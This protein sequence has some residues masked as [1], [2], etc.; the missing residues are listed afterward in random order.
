MPGGKS[1]VL[2]PGGLELGAAR[3]FHTTYNPP[4]LL[5]R[6]PSYPEL[7]VL[8]IWAPSPPYLLTNSW[9]KPSNLRSISK[10]RHFKGQDI[11]KIF[12]LFGLFCLHV[13]PISFCLFAH[14]PFLFLPSS[15]LH[16]STTGQLAQVPHSWLRSV[17]T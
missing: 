4:G 8:S 15:R 2:Q 9:S 12:C 1:C 16:R 3:W 6:V 11:R 5:A 17:E 13:V 10:G 14:S 7:N